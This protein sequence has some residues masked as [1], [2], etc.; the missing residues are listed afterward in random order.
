M[1]LY[2]SV[3][4]Q[5][6][7]WAFRYNRQQNHDDRIG[8]MLL[9]AAIAAAMGAILYLMFQANSP[10]P[11]Q[12]PFVADQCQELSNQGLPEYFAYS[13]LVT[14]GEEILV[15]GPFTVASRSL[16]DSNSVWAKRSVP[17]FAQSV[18]LHPHDPNWI[19]VG[20][21]KPD[22]GILVMHRTGGQPDRWYSLAALTNYQLTLKSMAVLPCQESSLSCSD[23]FRV[24]VPDEHGSLYTVAVPRTKQAQIACMEKRTYAKLTVEN[25]TDTLRIVDILPG[26]HVT[27]GLL[28]DTIYKTIAGMYFEPEDNLL[29]VVLSQSRVL[30]AMNM[31]SGKMER[32]K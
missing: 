31:T 24:I 2:A 4:Y 6:R 29:F 21:E 26:P 32:L 8:P 9:V 3:R 23:D 20:M 7:A 12:V 22:P 1:L 13:D 5:Y 27:A 10:L 11:H 28:D 18:D 15:T 30:R 25:S 14:S 17:G 16:S 19:I